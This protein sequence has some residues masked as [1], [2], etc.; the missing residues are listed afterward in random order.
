MTKASDVSEVLTISTPWCTIPDGCH[1]HTRRR[2][3]LKS[4]VKKKVAD[5]TLRM[6][7]RAAAMLAIDKQ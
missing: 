2:E 6:H 4:H 3:N 1:L 5:V 7:R